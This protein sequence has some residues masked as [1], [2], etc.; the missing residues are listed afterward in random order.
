MIPYKEVLDQY[1]KGLKIPEDVTIMWTDDNYGY[2]RRIS[3]EEE[4]KELAAAAFIT[5]LVI[6]DVLMIIC[7]CVQL[8]QV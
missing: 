7:G 6:G 2:I 1:N 5:T 3:N 8:N 4:Q